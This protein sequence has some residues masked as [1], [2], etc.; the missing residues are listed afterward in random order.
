MI[1]SEATA[2]SQAAGSKLFWSTTVPPASSVGVMS[3]PA[4]WEIG[5]QAR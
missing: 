4:A 5:A 1:R 2:A 3:I